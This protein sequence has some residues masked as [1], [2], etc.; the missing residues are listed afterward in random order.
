M[1]LSRAFRLLLALPLLLAVAGCDTTE[2][3]TFFTDPIEVV[4]TFEFDAE[5]FEPGQPAD[6]VQSVESVS[7]LNRLPRGFTADDIVSVRMQ[8]GS[9]E[10]SV[11]LPAEQ[12][13]IQILERAR[14]RLMQGTR[15]PLDVAT[16][17]DFPDTGRRAPLDVSSV[18]VATLTA[19]VQTGQ[20]NGLLTVTPSA[21]V[22]EDY[23]M[24]V[25]FKVIIEV[26]AD[27]QHRPF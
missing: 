22:T 10:I 16:Q 6:E 1:S 24:E 23:L 9:G 2:D 26:Q 18:D 5:D 15:S 11:L 27:A 19:F 4:F 14:L 25:R 21:T 12:N 13:A 20:F 7:L 8:Q 17:T 3:D